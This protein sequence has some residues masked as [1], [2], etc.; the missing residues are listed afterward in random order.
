[1]KKPLK[2][3]ILLI[4]EEI[5]KKDVANTELRRKLKKSIKTDKNQTLSTNKKVG[6]NC[7]IM[8]Y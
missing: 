3:V 5:I 7:H 2:N 4:V 6:N 1:M 8:N